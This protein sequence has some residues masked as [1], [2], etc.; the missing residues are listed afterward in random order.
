MWYFFQ[1]LLLILLFWAK[2]HFITILLTE[3]LR[4][5]FHNLITDGSIFDL[6][7]FVAVFNCGC[8][9]WIGATLHHHA[10]RA[11]GAHAT[12]SR[13]AQEP[14]KRSQT[15]RGPLQAN[16]RRGFCD[17]K[18]VRRFFFTASDFR[19]AKR[20][21]YAKTWQWSGWSWRA[22]TFSWT[23]TKC[24]C[25]KVSGN[26][27]CMQS[28]P[29]TFPTSLNAT[30][31]AESLFAWWIQNSTRGCVLRARRIVQTGRVSSLAK[32]LS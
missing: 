19:W 30:L 26:R 17:K 31:G 21:I 11:A 22:A 32:V 7:E 9:Y 6:I 14:G 12:R 3:V 23:W 8:W 18:S 5:K 29:A 4:K 16:A 20:K 1:K 24:S 25:D 27:I 2:Y 28:Q 13:G 10:A 15:T